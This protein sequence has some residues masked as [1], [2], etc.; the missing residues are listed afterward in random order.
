[1]KRAENCMNAKIN[2]IYF[3][4]DSLI[5]HFAKSKG[6]QTGEERVGPWHVYANPFKPHLCPVLALARYLF[7]YPNGLRGDIPLF[8]GTHQYNQ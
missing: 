8:E 3:Q 7:V 4:N 2:N 6:H 5:F 1:M